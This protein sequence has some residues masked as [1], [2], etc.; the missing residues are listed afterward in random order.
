MPAQLIHENQD[1]TTPLSVP[2]GPE[3]PL[4]LTRLATAKVAEQTGLPQTAVSTSLLRLFQ[5]G[6]VREVTGGKM[7]SLFACRPY[8]DHLSE[9]TEVLV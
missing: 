1:S 4:L 8:L 7:G 5:L 2:P 6:V 9:G 3:V